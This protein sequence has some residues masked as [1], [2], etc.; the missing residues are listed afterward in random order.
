MGE[1]IEKLNKLSLPAVILIASVILG[2]FYYVSQVNKQRSIERQQEVKIQDNRQTEEIKE[3]QQ[4]VELEKEQQIKV[5]Q[6]VLLD[7]CFK[8]AEA[9][10]AKATQDVID[11]GNRETTDENSGEMGKILQRM[12]DDYSEKFKND[13]DECFKRYPQK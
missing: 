9:M 4:Q 7:T 6:A 1:I 3:E 5:G 2:G 12:F 8:N 10:L 11:W 13:K